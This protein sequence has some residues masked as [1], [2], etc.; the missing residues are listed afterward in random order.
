[1]F[2]V[3]IFSYPPS[4]YAISVITAALLVAVP[5]AGIYWM[6]AGAESRLVRWSGYAALAL[7]AA[8]TFYW[9]SIP[10]DLF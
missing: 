1:M 2:G 9:P 5:L 3:Q 4:I 7:L 10:R 8:M 6:A